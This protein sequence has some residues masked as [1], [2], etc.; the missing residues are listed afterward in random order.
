MII[1]IFII[2]FFTAAGG[3]F[4]KKLKGK[5]GNIYLMIM[6][7][8]LFQTGIVFCFQMPIK[9]FGK[10]S[11]LHSIGV[12]HVKSLWNNHICRSIIGSLVPCSLISSS[13]FSY[14]N[15][16]SVISLCDITIAKCI[17][18]VCLSRNLLRNCNIFYW[19][20]VKSIYKVTFL[21][22][23]WWQWFVISF[24]N[25]QN[26]YIFQCKIWFWFHIEV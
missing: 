23:N 20:Y 19:L 22:L 16:Q 13:D 25:K 11:K 8:F 1:G 15:A 18:L 17:N 4:S 7:C 9:N 5:Y 21:S 2:L 3:K 14:H 26:T 10:G 12:R 6:A 24:K